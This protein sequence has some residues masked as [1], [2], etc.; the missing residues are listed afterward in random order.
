[1][2]NFHAQFPG[3]PGEADVASLAPCLRASSS[4]SAAVTGHL[5]RARSSKQAGEIRTFRSKKMRPDE[6]K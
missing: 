6:K 2:R 4:V 1:M 5:A 3:R